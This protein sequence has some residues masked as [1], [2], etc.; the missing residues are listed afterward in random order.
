MCP[1]EVM[2]RNLDPCVSGEPNALALSSYNVNTVALACAAPARAQS[3]DF[4][5]SPWKLAYT[6]F[7]RGGGGEGWGWGIHHFEP[8]II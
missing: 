4:L 8:L 3:W 6:L 1:H 7:W 2:T 5:A